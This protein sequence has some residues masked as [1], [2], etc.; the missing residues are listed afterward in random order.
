MRESESGELVDSFLVF[1]FV[2]NGADNDQRQIGIAV[3][4]AL[5]DPVHLV[6]GFEPGNDQMVAMFREIKLR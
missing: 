2:G 1:A 6:F 4:V 3:Q 5:D